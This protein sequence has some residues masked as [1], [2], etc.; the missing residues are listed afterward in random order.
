[1]AASL[2]TSTQPAVGIDVDAARIEARRSRLAPACRA[3]S[4]DDRGDR[5][6]V[7]LGPR[8][9]G[10]GRHRRPCTIAT[11]R[12]SPAE[13]RRIPA[14]RR[15]RRPAAQRGAP[16]PPAARSPARRAAPVA[17]DR[18]RQHVHARRADEVADEGVRRPLEQLDRRADLH[19]PAVV[20]HHHLV[21]EG[22]RLGLVVG[23]VDH[24]ALELR[25]AAPSASSAAAI[26]GAD[27]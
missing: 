15:A 18:A 11:G 21:G 25:G 13:A 4:A 24:R 9:C 2:L 8:R 22:Q 1:M 20:H 23:D 12:P 16:V 7:E 27:R 26:S 3:S 14:G 19:H 6:A 5:L 10:S 17:L